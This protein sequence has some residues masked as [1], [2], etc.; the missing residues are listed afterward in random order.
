MGVEAQAG[1]VAIAGVYIAGSVASLSRAEELSV[2]GR[3]GAV[4][5]GARNWQ[6]VVGV[7]DP[8]QGRLVGVR[9]LAASRMRA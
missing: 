9:L 6:G 8:G 1:I 5:P 2:G 7:D 4:T 3:G